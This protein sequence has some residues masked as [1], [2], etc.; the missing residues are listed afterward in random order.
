MVCGRPLND[1]EQ[2]ETLVLVLPLK[3]RLGQVPG[4]RTIM[5]PQVQ[6]VARRTFRVNT[7][8]AT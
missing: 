1:D 7:S 6:A 3:S 8:D 2:Q 4:Y 5:N